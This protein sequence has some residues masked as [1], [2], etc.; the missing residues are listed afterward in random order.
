MIWLEILHLCGR[1]NKKNN[2]NE[3]KGMK[4]REVCFD[5]LR[6]IS[7]LGV[8]IIHVCAMQWSI[9][10][11]HS[12][13]WACL[14]IY[15][16]L[17]KFSVPIFF[18]ISGR[19]FLDPTREMPIIKIW[20]KSLR[21]VVVFIFWSV[22]YTILNICRVIG[23]GSSL[24]ENLNWIIIEFFSGE[25]HMW[26]LYAILG[27]YLVTPILRKIVEN[28]SLIEYF[29]TLFIVFG[30]VWPTA[31]QIPKIGVLFS[32]IG[33]LMAFRMTTGYVGCY[34]LGYYLYKY[35]LSHKKKTIIYALG[36][37]GAVFSIVATLLVSW[38]TGS[39]SAKLASYLT[40]NVV[41]TSAAI[42]IAALNFFKNKKAN[43]TVTMISKYSFG[44]YLIHPLFLWIFEWI[45]FVPSICCTAI[46]VPLISLIALLLSLLLTVIFDKI[47]YLRK[48][49]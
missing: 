39:A 35:S 32:N 41:L 36:I 12:G 43:K 48:V 21:I 40:V 33:T 29:L 17:M 26:F 34:V 15:D 42:Y 2:F 11:I 18:M 37:L 1:F 47:P 24:K 25:Y 14:H 30:L 7:A 23:E 44:C 4:D 5:Y 16:M 22:V 3:E 20:N 27:L 46:S 9:L 8:I 38:K 28:K 19:F 10:D 6:I 31:E 49:I 45:G 13:Q